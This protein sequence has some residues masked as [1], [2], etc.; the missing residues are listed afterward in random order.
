MIEQNLEI[1]LTPEKEKKALLRAMLNKVPENK[2]VRLHMKKDALLFFQW[3]NLVPDLIVPTILSGIVSSMDYVSKNATPE[4]RP[5]LKEHQGYTV[6]NPRAKKIEERQLVPYYREI[7]VQREDY[8][9]RLSAPYE[10]VGYVARSSW[11]DAINLRAHPQ[12]HESTYQHE[13]FIDIKAIESL[14]VL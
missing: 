14:E 12:F 2:A 13:L 7:R 4:I 3:D 9:R 8:F 11:S 6:L 1:K 5:K 10:M